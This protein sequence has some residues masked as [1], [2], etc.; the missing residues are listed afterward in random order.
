MFLSI[1]DFDSEH[2]PYGESTYKR[3]DYYIRRQACKDTV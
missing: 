2:S 1:F 3:R